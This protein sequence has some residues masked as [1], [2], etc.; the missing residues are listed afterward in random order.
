MGSV[1]KRGTTSE[2]EEEEG[3]PNVAAPGQSAGSWENVLSVAGSR[4]SNLS[5]GDSWEEGII[6]LSPVQET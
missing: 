2:E 6:V 4:A 3:A 5:D 1:P